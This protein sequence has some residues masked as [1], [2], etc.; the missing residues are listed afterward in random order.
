MA[1]F[2]FNFDLGHRTC[3][4]R[5]ADAPSVPAPLRD[6]PPAREEFPRQR[7]CSVDQVQ[8]SPEVFLLKG[9]VTSEAASVLTDCQE[10]A[11]SDLVPGVYEG[12]FKL[13]EGATDLCKY[14]CEEWQYGCELMDTQEEFSQ[15]LKGK[16]VLELG[17]GHGL[18]GTVALLAGAEVHFQDFNSEVLHA[19]TSVTV[20]A[21]QGTLPESSQRAKVR[22]FSGDFRQ[23]PEKLIKEGLGGK[24][25]IIL[26]SETLYCEDTQ[27]PLMEAIR[28]CL[29][30]SG[31]IAYIA[32]KTHYF[33]VGGGTGRFK[34]MVEN[35][36]VMECKTVW[37]ASDGVSNQRE[38]LTLTFPGGSLPGGG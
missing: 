9:N 37:K 17:C 10:I 38:I 11:R 18:P 16:L 8:I 15:P 29:K 32:S 25:D 31:G 20:A 30:P 12:G 4:S 26:T 27:Y 35:S 24:Y 2:K 3:D 36:G 13:W 23:I 33:G 22:Y 19:L 28:Q 21:N 7:R 1:P 5:A 6:L 14:L 34:E